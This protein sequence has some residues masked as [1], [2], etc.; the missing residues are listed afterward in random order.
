MF[1]I[2]CLYRIRMHAIRI[3]I[4]S[5]LGTNLSICANNSTTLLQELTHVIVGLELPQAGF[6]VQVSVESEGLI[7]TESSVKLVWC[8]LANYIRILGL[9]SHKTIVCSEFR[10]VQKVGAAMSANTVSIFAESKLKVCE[11]TGRNGR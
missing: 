6:Q 2:N 9:I 3:T 5:H 8:H 11:L 1:A 7:T 10:D 4:Y